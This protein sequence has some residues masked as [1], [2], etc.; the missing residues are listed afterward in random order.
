M[1]SNTF[2]RVLL[3]TFGI[4]VSLTSVASDKATPTVGEQREAVLFWP[5]AQREAQFR[6]MY[7]LFPSD[8]AAHGASVHALPQGKRLALGDGVMGSY[9]DSHHLAGASA[10]SHPLA[11]LCFGLWADAAV[12]IFFGGEVGDLDAAGHRL[13]AR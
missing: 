1:K 8:R 3:V 10:W 2:S 6:K 9:M 11:A 13:A 4:A 7:E 5:Q 12:G